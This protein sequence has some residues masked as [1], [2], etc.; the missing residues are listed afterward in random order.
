[1][2]LLQIAAA[3]LTLGSVATSNPVPQTA[4]A[5][6]AKYC[7]ASTTICYSEWLSPEKIAF[8]VAIPDTATAGNFDVLLQ[9]AAPKA[10]GWAGIAW[11]GVMT[12][13]PLTLGWAN[14]DKT[15]VSSR[16]ARSVPLYG[17]Q[18]GSHPQSTSNYLMLTHSSLDLYAAPARIRPRTPALLTRSSPAR[19]PTARTGLLTCLPRASAHSE[20]P[21]ST[22]PGACHWRTP[23]PRRPPPSPPTTPAASAST[24]PTPSGRLTSRVL[25][26]PTLP[27]WSRRRLPSP[28]LDMDSWIDR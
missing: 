25:K 26:S 27:S 14:G 15:V 28:L 17:R 16:S 9:I 24:A 3:V 22:R 5:P 21:S 10:V 19:Q 18:N 13:N 1:M 20:A 2:G 7:D 12:N 11:G 8:R 4:A 23:H 6:A